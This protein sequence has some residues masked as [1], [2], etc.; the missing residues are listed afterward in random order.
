MF[1]I[2]DIAP[3]QY[4]NRTRKSTLFIMGIFII[5][6]FSTARLA[7]ISFGSYS[8]NHVVLNFLGAFIGLVITF[9]IVKIFYKDAKWM[10]EAMYGLHLKRQLM[11]IYNVLERIQKAVEQGDKEAMKI[12]RFYHL[13]TEQMHRFDDN[14]F[15]LIELKVKMQALEVKMQEQKIDL[16]Q[17]EFDIK[18]IDAYQ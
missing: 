7:V 10:K 8:N 4:R 16:N 9:W 14:T 11:A 5:I 1:K 3:E 2:E 6:G 17:T 15:E 18:S 13:G 12:L